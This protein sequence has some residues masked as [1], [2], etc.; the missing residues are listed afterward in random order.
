MLSILIPAYNYDITKLVKELHSQCILSTVNFE[1]IVA[2]DSPGMPLSV[3]NS[4]ISTLP[5][6]KF[7]QNKI[8]IGRTSTRNNLAGVAQ[9]DNL[10]FLDAD[11]QPVNSNFVAL[12]LQYAGK[13][14]EVVVGGYAYKPQASKKGENLRYKYGIE[15]EQKNAITRNKNPYENIFSGNF[16]THKHVFLENN[17]SVDDNL[18]GMDNY[19]SYKLYLN[20]VNIIHID[21][22]IYHMGLESD[23]VFFNKCL[24]SVKNRKLLLG[25]A[26]GIEN[27]NSL[28]RYYKTIKKFKAKGIIA[29]AFKLSNRILKRMI[30]KENPN[31][32]CLDLYRLG[33]MCTL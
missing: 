10:L 12:Y 25:N 17:Y 20:E 9:Y 28:L 8:N 22:P 5:N 33:Y 7:I 16:M 19:F 3:K 11:V 30:L 18:Y 15:R 6:C 4:E 26:S 1:I 32:F 2:D 31:L 13:R 14:N 24:E 27:I 23:D 21:N 29:F